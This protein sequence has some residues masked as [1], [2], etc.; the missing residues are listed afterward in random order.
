[1]TA[2]FQALLLI[3]AFLAVSQA[4]ECP[5]CSPEIAER[6]VEQGWPQPCVGSIT[7]DGGRRW[8]YGLCLK[9]LMKNACADIQTWVNAS[10]ETC[11]ECCNLDR[12]HQVSLWVKGC[13]KHMDGY[14]KYQRNWCEGHNRCPVTA[15]YLCLSTGPDYLKCS[16]WK[17]EWQMKWYTQC[18][19]RFCRCAEVCTPA[20]CKTARPTCGAS[21]PYLCLTGSNA[22]YCLNNKHG[23]PDSCS[24]CCDYRSCVNTCQRKCTPEECKNPCPAKFPYQCESGVNP[25]VCTSDPT[26]WVVHPQKC[27]KCCN[28][29]L[30]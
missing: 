23:N 22:S 1:M 15:P 26:Y 11:E 4:V 21:A 28:A 29:L 20:Q 13:R 3:G 6:I 5:P 16:K 12:V 30:C 17:S 24:S 9:G 10:R 27:T 18:D 25:G 2:L 8:G 14:P 7:M 19:T